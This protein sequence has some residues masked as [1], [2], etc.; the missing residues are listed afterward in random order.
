M[1]NRQHRSA[2]QNSRSRRSPHLLVLYLNFLLSGSFF[3]GHN[4]CS[5]WSSRC[6]TGIP[7]LLVIIRIPCL[8]CY[9]PWHRSHPVGRRRWYSSSCLSAG[10][11]SAV[12]SLPSHRCQLFY[13]LYAKAIT[14]YPLAL[15]GELEPLLI[16]RFHFELELLHALDN[17]CLSFCLCVGANLQDR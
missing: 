1:R 7:T 9:C 15:Q 6:A 12:L 14:F 2:W 10:N 13:S 3:A 5:S 11:S 4:A 16:C 17:S 8:T